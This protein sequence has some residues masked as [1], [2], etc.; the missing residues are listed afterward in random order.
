MDV[1]RA[2]IEGITQ[3]LI[4]FIVEDSDIPIEEAMAKVYNSIVFEKLSD[5]QTGLYRESSAYV[6]EMLKDEWAEG[7]LVQKEF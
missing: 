7:R 2:L 6:Y 1:K 4:L 5:F 3:D